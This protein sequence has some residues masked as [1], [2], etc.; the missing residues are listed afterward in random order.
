MYTTRQSANIRSFSNLNSYNINTDKVS[1]SLVAINNI[2]IV[3]G[4][5]SKFYPCYNNE[6][7]SFIYD[8]WIFLPLAI[9]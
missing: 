6:F 7:H 3:T 2:L 4:R 9:K 1:K 8:D 5:P